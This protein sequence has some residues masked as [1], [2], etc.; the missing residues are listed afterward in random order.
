MFI[1]KKKQ[2]CSFSDLKKG[3]INGDFGIGSNGKKV[4]LEL[5]DALDCI[6]IKDSGNRG[7]RRKPN[8]MDSDDNY[9]ERK[10]KVKSRRS[11][12]YGSSVVSYLFY[13]IF[14]FYFYFLILIFILQQY[15]YL[16]FIL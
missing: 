6:N 13:F 7:I 8:V 2:Y 12:M 10:N 16:V 3:L 15:F 14:I 9:E 11:R 4:F 1:L 5:K